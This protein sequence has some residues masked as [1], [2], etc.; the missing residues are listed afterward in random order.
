[1]TMSESD[2]KSELSAN[3][4]SI[5]PV[6]LVREIGLL[7]LSSIVKETA[8]DGDDYSAAAEQAVM[9][10]T[11]L[12]AA[13]INLIVEAARRECMSEDIDYCR[14]CLQKFTKAL[15]DR[16]IWLPVYALDDSVLLFPIPQLHEDSGCLEVVIRRLK[17]NSDPAE[18]Q[19]P[20][21]EIMKIPDFTRR[22]F[23]YLPTRSPLPL[24]EKIN[25]LKMLTV[26]CEEIMGVGCKG[27]A[28]E[29]LSVNYEDALKTLEN[30]PFI[31]PSTGPERYF[32]RGDE[33][34]I[35][36]PKILQFKD[37]FRQYLEAK[38][39]ESGGRLPKGTSIQKIRMGE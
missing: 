27:G 26:Y 20:L 25:F 30:A 2:E 34:V 36:Q 28:E 22:M 23:S 13:A 5:T 39:L 29:G 8:A 31:E 15:R 19:T 3:E 11:Q 12:E 21:E 38:A 7:P 14:S 32:H 6:S 4:E 35:D 37:C 10:R 1:M 17:P 18:Q 16:K 24:E 33:K 9:R